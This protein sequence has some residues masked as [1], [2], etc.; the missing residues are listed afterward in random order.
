MNKLTAAIVAFFLGVLVFTSL[1]VAPTEQAEASGVK[2][3]TLSEKNTVSLNTG[4]DGASASA[5]QSK[6]IALDHSL[7]K[8]KP[9]YMVLNSPGGSIDAGNAIIET[10]KGLSRK[11]HTISIFSASMSFI[12]SQYLDNRYMVDSGMMMSHRAAAG[13]MQGQVPG[14]LITR[15]QALLDSIRALQVPIARRA[16]YTPEQYES[17]VA[18][19]LWMGSGKA[20]ALRYSD[21][22]VRVRCDASLDGPGEEQEITVFVFR[23]KVRFHKCPLVTYPLSVDF[24]KDSMSA[25]WRRYILQMFNNRAQFVRSYG[26]LVQE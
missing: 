6:L 1:D 5:I 26:P 24:G 23:I 20:L 11:V 21:E 7:P 2:L 16:G 12:I 13:G 10:A 9:I 8:G 17:M 3:I 15:T 14:N 22:T 18:D 25:E 19:E 4:V